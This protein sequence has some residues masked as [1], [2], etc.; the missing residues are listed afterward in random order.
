MLKA[1]YAI[2]STVLCLTLA[3]FIGV[4]CI[5]VPQI[6]NLS[7]SFHVTP[8]PLT[9]FIFAVSSLTQAGWPV[10]VAG[11]GAC[12]IMLALRKGLGRPELSRTK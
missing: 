2:L 7:E 8:D 5:T 4:M 1:I 6:R 3:T 12:M 9:R 11:V 10:L